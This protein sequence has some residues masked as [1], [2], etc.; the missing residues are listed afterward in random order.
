[1]DTVIWWFGAVHIAAYAFAGALLATWAFVEWVLK[2]LHLKR[3][4]IRALHEY[5]KRKNA[6]ERIGA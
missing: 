4:L 5:Y 1:M 2:R 3:E 6:D